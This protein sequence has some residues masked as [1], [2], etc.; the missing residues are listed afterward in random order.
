M[1]EFELNPAL[2]AWIPVDVEATA[3][4]EPA[5]W[6]PVPREALRRV[7]SR[8]IVT[9]AADGE[10]RFLRL[11]ALKHFLANE[12][13]R[14]QT[15]KRGAGNAPLSLDDEEA[16]RRY[17]FEPADAVTPETLYERRWALAVRR[18]R[19]RRRFG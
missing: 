8:V 17:A 16:R 10:A 7:G 9:L 1:V 11:S 19:P 3:G 13:D 18:S 6:V 12:W 14:S 4:L 15:L 2:P 5:E